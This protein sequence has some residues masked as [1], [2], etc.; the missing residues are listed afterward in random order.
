MR[1][2][3]AEETNMSLQ[4]VN[5]VRNQT[6]GSSSPTFLTKLGRSKQ[7]RTSGAWQIATRYNHHHGSQTGR[8]VVDLSFTSRS[9][10]AHDDVLEMEK[11]YA[12]QSPEPQ[13]D[14]ALSTLNYE[15]P[16]GD[17]RTSAVGIEDRS[18]VHKYGPNLHVSSRSSSPG[19]FTAV[20]S[21]TPSGSMLAG[22]IL[23][24]TESVTVMDT[25][26]SVHRVA[27]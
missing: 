26:E 15:A 18:V 11:G 24:T 1:V 3:I 10:K 7:M 2:A 17:R 22:A 20:H 8:T 9:V 25:P 12:M 6:T 16:F 4:T 27:I 5:I 21:T 14:I 23:V 19:E 13:G